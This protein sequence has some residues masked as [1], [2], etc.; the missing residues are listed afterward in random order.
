MAT[1]LPPYLGSAEWKFHLC[2]MKTRKLFKTWESV[3]P[4]CQS[5]FINFSTDNVV[6][7]THMVNLEEICSSDRRHFLRPDFHELWT[8]WKTFFGSQINFFSKGQCR[9]KKSIDSLGLDW[10]DVLLWI[11]KKKIF[12][13]I[14]KKL[15]FSEF[16]RKKALLCVEK[17]LKNYLCWE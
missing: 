10:K 2:I 13:V 1:L 17:N 9:Q 14:R 15:N 12:L 4:L 6:S 7:F 11:I 16:R 3:P 8:F 5:W